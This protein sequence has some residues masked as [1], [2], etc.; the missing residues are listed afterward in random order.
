MIEFQVRKDDPTVHR[1]VESAD[2]DHA[3]S[4][5]QI[6][7]AIKTFGLSANNITYAVTGDQL[8][9]WQFFPPIGDETDGWGVMPVWGF[10]EVIESR[11]A[12]I[13]VGERIFGFFPAATEL[14]MTPT[15]VS[16]LRFTEGA[17]HRSKLPGTYNSYR[18]VSA[19]PGYD[20]ATDSERMLLRPLFVTSYCLWDSLHD[21]DWYGAQQIVILSA[22]SKTSIGL[23]YALQEDPD[24]PPV[25]GLTSSR[26]VDFVNTLRTYDVGL[27]YDALSSIDSHLP[28]L[29]VDLSG[30]SEIL[31]SLHA[32]LGDN[33]A[34]CVTVGIT[35]WQKTGKQQG[36]LADRSE[37]FFAP[38]HIQKRV[39][40]LGRIEF[41]Q[42]VSA[43]LSATAAKTR[44]WMKI[45]GTHGFDGFGALY[46][47]VC[48]GR[49]AA[50]QGIVVEL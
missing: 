49:I 8:G 46:S 3:I 26:H 28:T 13:D 22:S 20:R 33:L 41:D 18:R 2:A 21:K 27:A 47:D 34:M 14:T 23:S 45:V 37:F 50:D 25:T 9:Y 31:G 19:E 5:G 12:E 16:P 43:F 32:H 7:V 38:T 6:R 17:A 30:N 11:T 4:D 44:A 39:A 15:K 42:R 36:N 10:A 35:H 24:A 48:K 29:V 40:E 1:L